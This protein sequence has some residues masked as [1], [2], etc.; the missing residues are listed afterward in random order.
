M[1]LETC[2]E[3]RRGGKPAGVCQWSLKGKPHRKGI[4]EMRGMILGS[5]KGGRQ[6]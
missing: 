2:W 1:V 3:Q 4:L 5:V 6:Y